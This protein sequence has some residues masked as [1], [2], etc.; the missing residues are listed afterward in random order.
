MK[1]KRV[2]KFAVQGSSVILAMLFLG[3]L[4]SAQ[5]V[6]P[7]IQARRAAQVAILN[8]QFRQTGGFTSEQL[9]GFYTA[10]QLS[11]MIDSD[12]KSGANRTPTYYRIQRE[13]IDNYFHDEFLDRPTLLTETEASLVV[14][15]ANM[16]F[17]G[18]K[19]GLALAKAAGVSDAAGIQVITNAAA[20]TIATAASIYSHQ[21]NPTK[22][23]RNKDL[24]AN[25]QKQASENLNKILFT[26]FGKCD[27][28][29]NSCQAVEELVQQMGRPQG[30][31]PVIPFNLLATQRPD[32]IPQS[33]RVS[34]DGFLRFDSQAQ[35]NSAA[36]E[37]LNLTN[38][39]IIPDRQALKVESDPQVNGGFQAV[40]YGPVPDPAK[41]QA[42]V[43]R[44]QTRAAQKEVVLKAVDFSVQLIGLVNPKLAGQVE[45]IKHATVA[46]EAAVSSYLAAVREFKALGTA[47]SIKDKLKL[48]SSSFDFA[49]GLVGIGFQIFSMFGDSGP[50]ADQIILEQIQRLSQQIEGLRMEMHDRFDRIDGALNAILE[51]LHNRFGQIDYNQRIIIGDL[52]TIRTEL[53]SIQARLNRL[54]QYFGRWLQ[55]IQKDQFAQN[56][57][58]CLNYRRFGLGDM[59]ATE[60]IRCASFFSS[61]VTSTSLRDLW[62]GTGRTDFSDAGIA[63]NIFNFPLSVN[64]NWLAQF[65]AANLGLA[66][67]SATVLPN[68]YE[69]VLGTQ[70]YRQLLREW[71][72]YGANVS[73]TDLE[74]MEQLGYAVQNAVASGPTAGA[75]A[76]TPSP[77]FDALISKYRSKVSSLRNNVTLIE[78]NYITNPSNSVIDPAGRLTLNLWAGALAQ[79]TPWRPSL[80]TCGPVAVSLGDSLKSKIPT[81][82]AVGQV[83]GF[84]QATACVTVLAWA[85]EQTV[86]TQFGAASFAICG[87]FGGYRR[88]IVARISVALEF[89][90]AGVVIWRGQVTPS[91]SYTKES[92]AFLNC[93]QQG[94]GHQQNSAVSIVQSDWQGI[95]EPALNAVAPNLTTNEQAAVATLSTL[96]GQV[97]NVLR[98]H[99]HGIYGQTYS[100]LTAAGPANGSLKQVNGIKALILAYTSLLLPRT[101]EEND[102]VRAL[103]SGNQS[104]LGEEDIA[105]LYAKASSEPIPDITKKVDFTVVAE[106]RISALHESLRAILTKVAQG[107]P[108][109]RFD[110]IAD[111]LEYVGLSRIANSPVCTYVVSPTVLQVPATGGTVSAFVNTTQ[112][113]PWSVVGLPSWAHS[114]A[115]GS[116][117]GAAAIT[118]DPNSNSTPRSVPISV[119][120]QIVTLAQDAALPGLQTRGDFD[121]NGKTDVLWQ[122]DSTRQVGVWYMGG[123]QGNQFQSFGWLANPGVTGWSVV[124]MADLDGNG[125]PDLIWQNDA[126]RQV[127]AWYMGGAKG[128]QYQSFA[129][130]QSS[131]MPGWSLVS[132]A[133]LDGNGKPDLIWQEDA[134]RKV[135]VWFMG[136]MQGSVFQ[137]FAWLEGTGTPGWKVVGMGDLDGNG[138][139]D[140]IWQND[141]TR[142]VVAWY[143]GGASGAQYQSFAWLQNSNTPGWKVV[144]LA[145]LDGNAKPDLIWQE[146]ST[147]KVAAWYMGGTQGSQFLSFAWIEAN[148]IPGWTALS[149]K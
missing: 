109:E 77:L 72:Q 38:N 48:T 34:A 100:E 4:G 121:G 127:V 80:T 26:M 119:A 55:D 47:A 140:L 84:G 37:C 89:R 10:M 126:T 136:G 125:K 103:V 63:D 11:N 137:S 106:D 149:S 22:A 7:E 40:V 123:A 101:M 108:T 75:G 120:E 49:S 124:S 64:I 111:E 133:D 90:F 50:T 1:F 116:G 132:A 110:L 20:S 16:L 62:A 57:S 135:A 148:G 31:D 82:D 8:A 52:N 3:P 86:D 19:L 15:K 58:A 5:N 93:M 130:L 138:K 79:T 73:P 131:N 32:I 98:A 21:F 71:P 12:I 74:G 42:E 118:V 91:K 27:Q 61:W 113:C 60:F 141:T 81:L 115:S 17:S 13:R 45:T 144:G 41:T 139:L 145:D 96:V 69:W 85:G 68:P 67:L 44:L 88:D 117:P 87:N 25:Y 94:P 122:N 78:Q 95:F 29:P 105:T 35:A 56:V 112:S 53:I 39:A 129:W 54:E 92:W 43:L 65:P 147:R 99:Q 46:T 107:Q 104:I 128:E 36:N 142:Q 114:I 102:Y 14:W 18:S 28:S 70:A 143:M 30:L 6:V 59:P 66:P 83:L 76:T 51:T 33:L 97:E 24:I 146:D 9:S 134:T 23:I 2:V